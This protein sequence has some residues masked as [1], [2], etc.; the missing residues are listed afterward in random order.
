MIEN[1]TKKKKSESDVIIRVETDDLYFI[2]TKP[3]ITIV[4][5]SD[6]FF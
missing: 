6:L 5:D 1:K 2:G 4:C 3:L